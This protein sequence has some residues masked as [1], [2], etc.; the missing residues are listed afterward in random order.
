MKRED[1][2]SIMLTFIMGVIAGSFLYLTQFASIETKLSTPSQETALELNVVAEAYAG[3][4]PNCPSFQISQD[5]AYRYFRVLEEGEDPVLQEGVMPFAIMS[6]IKKRLT[7]KSLEEQSL[8]KPL[9]TCEQDSK[10]VQIRY[11]ITL[12]NET[13]YL[14]SCSGKVDFSSHLWQ[15]LNRVWIYLKE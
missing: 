14:D 10:E 4:D 5:G 3:C 1:M 6:E 9:I 12:D 13:Y 11:V 8:A 15:S 7:A 2:I